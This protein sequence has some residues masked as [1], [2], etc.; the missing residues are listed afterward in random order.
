LEYLPEFFSSKFERITPGIVANNWM[1]H[2][3]RQSKYLG[4]VIIGVTVIIRVTVYHMQT[5]DS[6]TGTF[7]DLLNQYVNYAVQSQIHP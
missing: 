3:R 1:L 5:G 7:L 2:K 4:F 6:T